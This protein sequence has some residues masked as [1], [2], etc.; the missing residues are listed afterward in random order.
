MQGR[1]FSHNIVF[2]APRTVAVELEPVPALQPGQVLCKARKSLL[3]I[4]TETFCLRGEADPETY[5][6]D[7]IRYPFHA[8]YSMAAEVIAVAQDVPAW[9]VGDRVTSLHEHRQSFLAREHELF[10]V[11]DCIS[12]VE[13]TWASLGRTTQVGVRR[14]ELQLGETAVVVGLGILGQLVTQ[15][16]SLMGLRRIIV[17][18][19]SEPR[20]KLALVGGATHM[21]CGTAQQARGE[22]EKITGGR[23]ADVVFE[24]TGHPAVLSPATLLLR[25]LGRLVLLGDSP[26]PS[27]QALGPRVVGDSLSI[28]GIHG[29]MYPDHPTPFNPWTAAEMTSL[30]FDFLRQK[31]MDVA[32]LVSRMVSPMDAVAVYEELLAGPSGDVGIIFDWEA[33]DFPG[34]QGVGAG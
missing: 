29:F 26:K 21:V 17:V 18:D 12:D 24:I 3:S 34:G 25:R 11:P 23:M 4:G 20:C 32:R 28:L 33:L 14:A 1:Q 13:A 8:G 7:F 9:K 5:W 22:I 2:P 16:L 6:A 15:Y 27:L 19:T 10:A 31:R 30:F